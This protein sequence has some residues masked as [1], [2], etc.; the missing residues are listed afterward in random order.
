ML[1]AMHVLAESRE[2]RVLVADDE[3]IIADTLRT[4]LNQNGFEAASVYG[5][6]DAIDMA[7]VWTPDIFLTD[8]VMPGM[9][10]IEAAI[11]IREMIPECRVLLFSGN[12]GTSDLRDEAQ[13]QGHHFEMLQKPLHPIE[14]LAHL[15]GL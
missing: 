3:R 10:G 11:L 15:R 12:A 2:L 14:L 4:I 8:V 13:L 7:H 6:Q 9:N 1:A 5:G